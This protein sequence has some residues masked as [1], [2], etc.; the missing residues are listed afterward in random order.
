MSDLNCYARPFTKTSEEE[1]VKKHGQAILE[2]Q[3]YKPAKKK[4]WPFWVA[5]AAIVALSLFK[6][7]VAHAQELTASYY[8]RAS[9]IQEGTAKYNPG[10]IMANGK[11]FYDNN[12]TCACNSYK[13]GDRL[14]VTGR[15]GRSVV[16]VV[17]DRTAKRFTGKRIDL[18]IS[19]FS[20]ISDTCRGL[21][22]VMVEKI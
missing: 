1:A 17:T 11:V 20:K 13:L 16:V 4:V 18:S 2:S 21:E 19:A 12:F 5:I 14:R 9:L 7:C 3:G 6:G 15:D 22:K 10:F 8:S